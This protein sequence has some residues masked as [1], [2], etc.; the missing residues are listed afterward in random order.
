MR[1]MNFFP[2]WWR[3]FWC[4][5]V[6]LALPSVAFALNNCFTCKQEI[7]GGIY[8]GTDQ[9]TGAE[10]LLCSNC[11]MLP[12]CFLCGL[13]AKINPTVLPDGRYLCERDT[14]SVVLDADTAKR[15][16]EQVRDDLDR[17]FSRF[18]TFPANVD[19][20]VIDRIDTFSLF[21][22]TGFDF[23]SPNLLGCIR[24]V[25]SSAGKRYW[26][27][28]MTGQ[29]PPGLKATCAHEFSHAWVGDNVPPE[30]RARLARDA[31]EGFCE[32][33]AFRLMDAQHEEEQKQILL[34]NRYT[35]GQIYLFIAAEQ[36]Y[37]FDQILDWMKWGNAA[38]LEPGHL[39][40]IREVTLPVARP[41]AARPVVTNTNSVAGK[42][43]SS[44]RP[45]L[46]APVIAA[47]KLNGIFWEKSPLAIVNG[48]AFAVGEV[49]P[50]KFGQSNRVIQCIAIR[51]KSVIIQQVASGAETELSLP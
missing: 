44:P 8:T 41:L 25:S 36:R 43:N 19:V 6:C 17:Q 11:L 24:P 15:I 12:R 46:S 30:R 48:R 47:F 7:T 23:E 42:T 14:K 49:W 37:G 22:Q 28:L 50:V 38:F 32:M 51:E 29:T 5:A 27:Q 35:R 20:E 1:S 33:I 45:A 31:E 4:V 3:P 18:A 13:P 39:D 40:K 26:M 16:C 10:V 21:H 9:I 34:R 2:A